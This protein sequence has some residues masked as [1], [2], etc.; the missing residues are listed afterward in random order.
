MEE[1]WRSEIWLLKT[2]WRLMLPAYGSN[3]FFS[4]RKT[5]AFPSRT[6][7]KV[8]GERPV[9]FKHGGNSSFWSRKNRR[10]HGTWKIFSLTNPWLGWRFDLRFCLRHGS[11]QVFFIFYFLVFVWSTFKTQNRHWKVTW[12]TPRNNPMGRLM[13][14]ARRCR[15]DS[16]NPRCV[17]TKYARW[18]NVHCRHHQA[19]NFSESERPTPQ[20]GASFGSWIFF[21]RPRLD[22]Q[23]NRGRGSMDWTITKSPLHLGELVGISV[24]RWVP[25]FLFSRF[26]RVFSVDLLKHMIPKNG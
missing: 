23:K 21:W 4:I 11:F 14:G 3:R 7:K 24:S 5:P 22:A 26:F 15:F 6:A 13:A 9:N 12:T 20:A 2:F 17:K 10:S 25:M 18:S 8:L 1:V 16:Q 19:E